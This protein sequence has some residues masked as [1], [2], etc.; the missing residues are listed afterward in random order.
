MIFQTVCDT[1]KTNNNK[2]QS[3]YDNSNSNNNKTPH[4]HISHNN[5]GK[6]AY[7]VLHQIFKLAAVL[8]LSLTNQ[9]D[10]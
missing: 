10:L 2:A 4:R 3:Y 1:N 8:H 9:Y 7:T 6:I 5:Q